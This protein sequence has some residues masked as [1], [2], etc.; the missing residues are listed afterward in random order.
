[1]EETV[2][3]KLERLRIFEEKQKKANESVIR[4]KKRPE[5]IEKQKEYQKQY[6][7][8]YYQR[9]KEEIKLMKKKLELFEQG[10]KF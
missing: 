5:Y 4:S 7:K 1:M 10:I 8:E 9:K 6:Q 3:E 2:E